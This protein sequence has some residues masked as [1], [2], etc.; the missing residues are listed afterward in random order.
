ME[1]YKQRKKNAW[2]F[3]LLLSHGLFL[4]FLDNRLFDSNTQLKAENLRLVVENEKIR[5]SGV[6]SGGDSTIE[7]G[8]IQLLEKKLLIQQEELTDLHKRKGE[9]SQQ[10]IDLNVKITVLQKQI[11]EKDAR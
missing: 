7:S 5:L 8:R 1:K 9:N 11:G 10:I 2:D 4:F 6:P 3:G